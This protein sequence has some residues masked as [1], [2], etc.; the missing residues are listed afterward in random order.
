MQNHKRFSEILQ[1]NALEKLQR[2][3]DATK[4][5]GDLT[6]LPSGTYE[7]HATDGTLG[8]SR[9]KGTPFYKLTFR[10]CEGEHQGRHFWHDVYLTE[11]A[12]PL[13]KRDLAKLGIQRLEQL[14][15]P[16]PALF[17][18]RVKVALRKSDD[19][20]EFNAVKTFEVIGIDKPEAD[21]FAP[22]GPQPSNGVAG[23]AE[24]GAV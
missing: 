11:A 15:Q 17:R 20:N 24:R 10:V 18:C 3:F 8:T 16:L 7:A 5:A 12:M 13:A 21:P 23:Q 6:P 4:A 14:Q 22:Q 9:S 1:G 19:G 2:A